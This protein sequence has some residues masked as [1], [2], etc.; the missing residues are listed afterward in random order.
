[1]SILDMKHPGEDVGSRIYG[2][3]VPGGNRDV[4]SYFGILKTSD[5]KHR[6]ERESL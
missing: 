1:M 5:D 3:G 4:Y 2:F 6:Y